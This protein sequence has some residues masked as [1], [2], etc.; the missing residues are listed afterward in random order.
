MKKKSKFT[1]LHDGEFYAWIKTRHLTTH[2]IS[3]IDFLVVLGVKIKRGYVLRLFF[4][5][6]LCSAISFRMSRREL[7]FDM[8][9][10]R[11]I[12]KNI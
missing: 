11:P 7:F 9:E 12:L 10:H 3:G 6:D 2:S 5:I 8:A 4:N 1:L